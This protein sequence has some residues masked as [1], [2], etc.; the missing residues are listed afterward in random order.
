MITLTAVDPA[1][2]LSPQLMSTGHA[3]PTDRD[4]NPTG[5]CRGDQAI[6]DPRRS[7]R[8]VRDDKHAISEPG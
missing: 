7:A 5:C 8:L 6:R 2:A 3:G 4:Q 1:A